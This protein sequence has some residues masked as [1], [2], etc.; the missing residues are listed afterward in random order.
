[1]RKVLENRSLSD[2]ERMEALENQLKEARFLAEEADRKYDEVRANWLEP[3][4]DFWFQPLRSF[5]VRFVTLNLFLDLIILPTCSNIRFTLFWLISIL[6]IICI[7]V[8]QKKIN[9]HEYLDLDVVICFPFS[10]YFLHVFIFISIFQTL[11]KLFQWPGCAEARNGGGW[12]R[13]GRG[14]RRDWRVQDR[15]AGGGV[16]SRWKQLEISGSLWGKGESWRHETWV[17]RFRQMQ[18]FST[19]YQKPSARVIMQ[20][21]RLKCYL[22]HKCKTICNRRTREKNLTRNR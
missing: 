9:V 20:L 22:P 6:V 19:V 1:M 13:A 5:I 14:A 21:C 4:H 17:W 3:F 8:V 7:V 10:L 16:E 12:P 15:G 2:E 18:L 11:L